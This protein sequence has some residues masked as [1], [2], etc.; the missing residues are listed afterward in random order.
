MNP[1]Q[2]NPETGMVLDPQSGLRFKVNPSGALIL[3]S[4]QNGES[5]CDLLKDLAQTCGLTPS[6][7]E[8]SYLTFTRQCRAAGLRPPAV[9]TL[10]TPSGIRSD[11]RN[12]SAA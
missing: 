3:K 5:L 12:S 1:L 2:L 6:Q 8:R 9:P 7:A 11:P 10:G 4:W